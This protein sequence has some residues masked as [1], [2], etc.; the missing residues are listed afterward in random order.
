MRHARTLAGVA[1][2]FTDAADGDFRPALGPRPVAGL[3]TPVRVRQVHGVRV[4]RASEVVSA[5]EAD[6]LIALPGD[7]PVAI[8]VAD[9]VPILL[10]APRVVAAVHAGWRGTAARAVLHAAD[11]ACSAGGCAP[12]DL[13]AAIGPAIGGCC[14]EVGEEVRA[15]LAHVA[16]GSA[17]RSGRHVDLVEVNRALLASVGVR[18]EV[19]AGCTR[20]GMGYFSHRRDGA[21]AGRMLAA[22][23]PP[24]AR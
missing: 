4:A 7:P 20:C 3:G 13:V 12:T 22:I 1:H 21:A 18:V 11:A 6:A 23:G 2:A 9:C 16:P 15:A 24:R 5:S 14:Y 8:A 10:A 19:V 17:W